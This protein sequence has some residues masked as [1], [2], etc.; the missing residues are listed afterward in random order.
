MS[1]GSSWKEECGVFGVW[2]HED[3]SRLTYLG[4][5]AMQHRGQESA[6]IVSCHEGLHL[7]HKGL[8][9]VGD[10]FH[11]PELLSLQGRMSIGHVRYSTTGQNLLAN[12][13]P[14]LANLVSGPV[15][16]AHN[17]NIVNSKQLRSGLQ[18][19]GAIFQGTNDTEILL[20]Q[21]ARVPSSDI[22]ECLKKA[23]PQL[24]GA[25]SFVLMTHDKLVALRD[26]L[27]FRPL[28]LGKKM[29]EKGQW[30]PV[31]ASETCAFDLIGAQLVREIEPGE[32][33]WV[34]KNGEHS[35]RF[36]PKSIN[37]QHAK[38]IFEHV[39]FARP[40]SIVFGRSVYEARKKFGRWLAK[41][42]PVDADVVIPVPDGGIPAALGYSL[43]SGIPFEHGIIRN[44]YVGRTFIQPHQSI[45]SFGVKIK[46][47]PQSA[48]L[49][50]KR[51][52]VVDDSLV[53][54][55]TSQK[56]IALVRQAGAKEVHLRIASPPTI[57]PCYYGVDT[58]QKSQLIAALQSIEEIRKFV[59]ADSLAYIS[60]EGLFAAF[61]EAP[62]PGAKSFCAACFDGH[63]P[64]PLM[65]G[66]LSS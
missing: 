27:G 42:A 38:C 4:L 46:L 17:G 32:I 34:D 58:P 47:N 49:A 55:T 2:D 12:A 64:T 30:S 11:E 43:E 63:Y 15:A 50:G 26:P 6:G 21:I 61:G 60:L 56:I 10:V 13:Q 51:V 40:D 45:R 52:I 66:A 9:L 35:E 53:R 37:T 23:L 25:Y 14:L 20:H 7:S 62:V 44:H 41:E 1:R 16:L 5:Y 28:V 19:Q 31:V 8:G 39:Y 24:V 33:F 65:D 54:G 3:A 48:V 29:N 59:E 36:A 18:D 57:G 22:V